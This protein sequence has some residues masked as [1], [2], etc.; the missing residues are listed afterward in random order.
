[1]A[2]MSVA[3]LVWLGL[4]GL[5]VCGCTCMVC[6]ALG[7]SRQHGLQSLCGLYGYIAVLVWLVWLGLYGLYSCSCT[8]MAC[9]AGSV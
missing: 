3:V 5:Y 8:C 7:T 2:C 1:M 9:M 4:H 6:M